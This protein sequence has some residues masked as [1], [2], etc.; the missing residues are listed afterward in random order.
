MFLTQFLNYG[1][2]SLLLLNYSS[3]PVGPIKGPFI[4]NFEEWQS[5][6]DDFLNVYQVSMFRSVSHNEVYRS[7]ITDLVTSSVRY[8]VISREPAAAAAA[9]SSCTATAQR[10]SCAGHVMC[11]MTRSCGPFV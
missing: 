7:A 11:L 9:T 3:E 1:R 2:N 10:T 4:F 6:C 5:L 8:R